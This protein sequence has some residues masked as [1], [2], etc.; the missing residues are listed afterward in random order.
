MLIN[1]PIVREIAKEQKITPETLKLAEARAL[2]NQSSI[3]EELVKVGAISEFDFVEAASTMYNIPIASADEMLQGMDYSLVSL[4]PPL[5]LERGQMVPI[6]KEGKTL[7]IASAHPIA[8]FSEVSLA[9]G[10][11]QTKPYLLTLTD[12]RRIISLIRLSSENKSQQA[13]HQADNPDEQIGD[14]EYQSRMVALFEGI[15]LDAIGSRASDIHLER[16]EDKVRLRYRID[17]YLEDITR[18]SITALELRGIVNVVKINANMDIT[19]KR[20]PQGG[21]MRRRAG[22]KIFDLRIQ[23]QPSLH[24]E[25]LVIR[26]LP[27][28]TNLITV[29]DL[30]FQP[31]EAARYRRVINSPQGLILIVGPTGSGKST[32]LYAGLTELASDHSIKI[33]TV[34]DPIEYAISGV[35][36]TQVHSEIGFNFADAMR[37]F[38]REDPDVIL[39]GEI[40]DHETALEAIR[41]SQ[42]GHLVLSTLHCNDAVDAVQ[43]LFDLGLHPN[44]LA[45]ELIAVIAQRLVRRVCEHCREPDVPDP[46]ILSEL[47]GGQVPMNFKCFKGRGCSKCDGKGTRGRVATFEFLRASEEMRQGIAKS[48]TVD[49]LRHIAY[50]TG[51]KPI[52]NHL[53]E[54]VLRGITPLEE[55]PK[56]LS[57]EQMAPHKMVQETH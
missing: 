13:Q 46:Q 14:R 20:L 29:E 41:A 17:G 39:V 4:I 3:G 45:G 19:E 37:A 56:T 44:S 15:L 43:R 51:M 2:K 47:F 11:N 22:E 1:D 26:L 36:Q 12:F 50:R 49:E 38:V 16:Y 5:Y 6:R 10:C 54:L 7:V 53:I 23:T 9:L 25:H 35:Q 48:M 31:D 21:R 33:I 28:N 40:R 42:T 52:R 18:I 30:G 57:I 24:G 34:E 55:V 32:T 27:Q 8:Q